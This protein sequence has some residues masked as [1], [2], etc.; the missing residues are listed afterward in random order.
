M[1]ARR[2]FLHPLAAAAAVLIALLLAAGCGGSSST[3]R[4]AA[5]VTSKETLN[6]YFQ[7]TKPDGDHD[8][9][10]EE[11]DEDDGH[12]LAASDRDGDNDS[13]SRGLYDSDDKSVA[14]FGRLARPA[15][16]AAITALVRRYYA[17]AARHD[18]TA[19][20]SMIYSLFVEAIPEDYGTSPPGPGYAR[21]STCPQVVTKAFTHFRER[22]AREVATLRVAQVRVHDL[23]AIALLSS[24]APLPERTLE[25]I[26]EGHTWRILAVFDQEVS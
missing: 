23:R 6:A 25:A 1:S 2:S 14:H 4:T 12:K 19:A 16:R 9:D 3:D 11:P 26:R 20:C 13:H 5:R 18:G 21:G 15:E 24:A 8:S 7:E 22:I 10:R 17:A